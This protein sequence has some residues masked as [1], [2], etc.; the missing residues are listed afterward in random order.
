MSGVSIGSTP[1]FDERVADG[2]R[3]EMLGDVLHDLRLEA[4][5]DHGRRHLAG[6]EAGNLRGA[7]QLRRGVADG[8]IDHRARHLDREIAACFVHVDNF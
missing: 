8:F 4:L 1:L 7:A 6:P 5:A 2:L 3:H